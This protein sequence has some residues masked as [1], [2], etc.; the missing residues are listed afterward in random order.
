MFENFGSNLYVCTIFT[1]LEFVMVRRLKNQKF[2]TSNIEAISTVQ[3]KSD[4]T[5]TP[6]LVILNLGNKS[7]RQR[8]ELICVGKSRR[9][10]VSIFFSF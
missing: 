6:S 4:A 9:S 10:N 5:R 8:K 7:L 1:K 2:L 3:S